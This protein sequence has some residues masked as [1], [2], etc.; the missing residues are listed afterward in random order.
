MSVSRYN[1]TFYLQIE[2]ANAIA[3]TLLSQLSRITIID[4]LSDFR[5]KGSGNQI[6]LE[7]P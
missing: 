4:S 2:H 1:S 5:K 7:S 6:D 3:S